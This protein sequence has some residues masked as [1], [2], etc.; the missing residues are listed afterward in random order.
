MTDKYIVTQ[1]P[2][3]RKKRAKKKPVLEEVSD[4]SKDHKYKLLS[5]IIAKQ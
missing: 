1:P 5:P 4:I 2:N 3:P